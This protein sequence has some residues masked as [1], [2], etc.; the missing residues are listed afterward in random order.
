M[1]EVDVNQRVTISLALF[2]SL[3]K[4]AAQRDSIAS[5]IKKDKVCDGSDIRAILC[6]GE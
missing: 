5:F 1:N 4:K 3:C 6:E 2:L